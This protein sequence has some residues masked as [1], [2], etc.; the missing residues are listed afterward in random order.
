[1][2]TDT[3]APWADRVLTKDP[4][5]SASWLKAHEG[6]FGGH[7]IASIL[8]VGRK[9]PFQLWAEF[10]NKVEKEDISKL[11]WVRRGNALEPVVAQLYSETT[12]RELMPSPGMIRHPTIPFIAGTPDRLVETPERG[13]GIAE[14]KTIGFWKRDAWENGIP[15]DFQVQCHVYMAVMQVEWFTISAMPIDDRRDETEPILWMD[16]VID[17]VFMDFM[18]DE[19]GTFYDEH[20]TRD[21]P[22]PALQDDAS[23]LRRMFKREVTGTVVKLSDL[24]GDLWA[25]RRELLAQKREIEKRA[26]EVAATI[27]QAMGD[28]EWAELPGGGVL[29]WRVEPRKGHVVA[30]SEPR[31]LREMGQ[32]K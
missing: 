18:L 17:P 9:T 11:P 14:L 31:A 28:A 23:V 29:R 7:D 21:I 6:V 32:I 15:L 22:P 20:I 24:H 27:Q 25:E 13:L 4:P 10:T 8:G 19:V 16:A 2:T 26:E 5:G 12:G 30:P 3:L 1:M